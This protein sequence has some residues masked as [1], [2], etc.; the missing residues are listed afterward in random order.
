MHPK[1]DSGLTRSFPIDSTCEIS[2]TCSL[3]FHNF[4]RQLKVAM[5]AIPHSHIYLA[6]YIIIFIYKIAIFSPNDS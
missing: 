2:V 3:H 5:H 1:L 6:S 4:I